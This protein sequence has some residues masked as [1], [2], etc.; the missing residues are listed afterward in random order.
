[1]NLK[2]AL[3]NGRTKGV[4]VKFPYKGTPLGYRVLLRGEEG[5]RTAIVVGFAEEGEDVSLE[6]PDEKPLTTDKHIRAILETAHHY[7]VLPW[8]LLFDLV[9]SLFNWREEEYITLGNKE[10]KFVDRISKEILQYVK[11]RR[12]VKEENLKK[13]FGKDAVEKLLELGFLRRARGWKMPELKLTLYSLA[14]PLEEAILRLRGFKDIEEKL[15]LLYY[16]QERRVV[17]QEELEEAG[18]RKGDIKVLLRRGVIEEREGGIR[19]V[20]APQNLLQE[21]RS[22]LKPLGKNSIIFGSWEEVF[23]R[24]SLELDALVREGKSAFL[25][26]DSLQLIEVLHERL[27]PLLGDRLLRLSSREKPRDFIQNWF[28]LESAKGVVVLGSRVALLAPFKSLDLVLSFGDE[29]QKIPGGVDLRYFLYRL[30]QYYGANFSVITANPPLSL[31][32]KEDWQKEYYPPASEVLL[33]RRK[34]NEVISKEL[35]GIINK[36]E[37]CLFLVNKTGYA[38]AFC[39]FCGWMAECPRCGSFLTLSMDRERVFCTNCGYKGEAKC[40]EC[41]RALQELGFGIEK[42]TE[43]VYKRFGIRENFHFDTVPRLHKSY[44]RVVVLHADNILSVP[45]FDAAERYF[46]YLWKAL[47][48][49]RKN[50]TVQTALE[51][52]PLLKYVKDKDWQGFCQEELRKREEEE[53]PPFK[54]LVKAK[55]KTLP[56]IKSLPGE[57]RKKNL[58]DYFELLI[59]VDRKNLRELLLEIRKHR[60]FELEVL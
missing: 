53:L 31:C 1:M 55:L 7:A 56:V 9:P 52:N 42:A 12:E 25:F 40:P 4:R 60:P 10:W 29:P 47:C 50:L 18:F 27:Y 21:R 8:H 5:G 3:P 19:G 48:I 16:L 13:R 26:C 43:E 59:K 41:G 32:L 39:T 33:F 23:L 49:S 57:V 30:S 36:E 38:Y 17:S 54:R 15:K 51:N 20:R 37:E 24:I 34:G 14:I 11:K 45:W 35:E 58:G 46:S 6:F 44:D 28:S 22:Y 2:L